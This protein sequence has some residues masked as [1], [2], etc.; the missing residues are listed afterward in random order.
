VRLRLPISDAC[1]E[2]TKLLGGGATLRIVLMKTGFAPRHKQSLKEQPVR[3]VSQKIFIHCGR[4]IMLM[5]VN[6]SNTRCEQ[7]MQTRSDLRN[8]PQNHSARQ[9]IGITSG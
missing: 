9:P 7:P 1:R 8:G 6:I 4:V 5:A 2:L 3:R